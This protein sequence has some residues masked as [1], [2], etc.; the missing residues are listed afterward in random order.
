MTSTAPTDAPSRLPEA[1][2]RPEAIIFDM[3]GTLLDTESL[4]RRSQREAAHALGHDLPEDLHRQFVGVHREV[5]DLHLQRLWG[6]DADVAAFTPTPTNCSMSCG[7]PIF[8]CAPVPAN[9][10]RRLP[11]PASRWACARRRAVRSRRR[12]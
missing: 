2:F 1:P 7:A 10:S 4:Y 8:R 9:C 12:S 6:E 5:N 3:D 11:R